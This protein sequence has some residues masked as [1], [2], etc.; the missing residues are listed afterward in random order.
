MPIPVYVVL[1]VAVCN[2][3]TWIY[4]PYMSPIIAFSAYVEEHLSLQQ[5]LLMLPEM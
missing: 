3:H 4:N 1:N 2:L 5:A